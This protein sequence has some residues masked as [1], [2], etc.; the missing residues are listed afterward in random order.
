MARN[1]EKMHLTFI[2]A[3]SKNEIPV[4]YEGSV[5]DNFA[6]N[7]VVVVEGRLDTTGVFLADTLITKCEWKYKVKVK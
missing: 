2:L 5:P 3:G 7:R 6:E 1:L 4:Y